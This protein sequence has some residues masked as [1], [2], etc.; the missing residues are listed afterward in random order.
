LRDAGYATGVA[1]KWQINDFRIQPNILKRHGFDEWLMW[2]GGE[3]D[4]PPSDERYWDAYIYSSAEGQK[5]AVQGRVR[6][7]AVQRVRARLLWRATRTSRC[8]SY[9]PM[10]LTHTPF[11]ETPHEPY[12]ESNLERHKAMTRYVDYLVGR[13]M[14][15][16]ERLGVWDNT[17]VFFSTDNGTVGSISGRMNGRLVRGGK[18]KLTENGPRQPFIVTGPG[19]AAGATSDALTDFSDLLPTFLE[20]AGAKS[21]DGYE[22][23]GHS[24]AG[25]LHG[26]DPDGPRDWMLAMGYGPAYLDEQGVRPVQVF[27]DRVV[28]DKRYKIYVLDGR[29]SKLFDLQDDPAEERNLI[30]SAEAEHRAA[31]LRLSAVVEGFPRRDARPRYDPTPPQPWDVTPEEINPKALAR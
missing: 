2:T 30:D 7:A 13:V 24:I 15:Q 6:A 20:L 14:R 11:V 28:R 27:T 9:Y 25:V 10:A 31:L 12:A 19:V 1:G 22:I 4:N 26:R 5:P 17:Y 23:D 8:W 16:L 21:P 3:A 29:V 18:A